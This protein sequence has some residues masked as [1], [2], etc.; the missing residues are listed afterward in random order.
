[1]Y[2]DLSIT[3]IIPCLNEE[4]GIEKVLR[5]MPPF[6]DQ[7]IVVDNGSTDRTSDV[8][9]GLGAEVIRED[10]RGYGR[11]YK[12]GF[13]KATGD[14]IVTLDGDHSYPPDAIS[15]LIEAF[16]HLEVDFLNASRF[17]V[18]DKRAMSFKH[19]FGN[20]VLSLAMSLLFFRWVSDSQSGMWVFRRSILNGMKLESDGM[21]F[22]EEIKI[23]ALRSARVRFEE[24]P[25]QYSSRL[26]EI[27]LNPW[28]DGF[29]N[30]WFLLRKRFAR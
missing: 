23:E 16:L 19:K 8:A 25:V 5:R 24:I 2:K 10:V 28:R 20:F 15:Y 17:P 7:V 4:Q 27:K 13:A 29:H 6:V 18:R 21:A 26:G 22:S 3:V 1:M 14:I 9:R 30:L 11:A 12:T